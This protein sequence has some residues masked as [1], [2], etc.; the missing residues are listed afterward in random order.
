MLPS[1]RWKSL[2]LLFRTFE[3]ILRLLCE[4]QIQGIQ[5]CTQCASQC[6]IISDSYLLCICIHS[7]TVASIKDLVVLTGVRWF[8]TAVS[9]STSPASA[10]RFSRKRRTRVTGYMPFSSIPSAIF[11]ASPQRSAL[12]KLSTNDDRL[13]ADKV[14]PAVLSILEQIKKSE[15]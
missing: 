7:S 1:K 13:L 3:K 14:W 6:S 10:R 9:V 8:P 12:T 5:L 15:I 2:Q 11:D 4:L